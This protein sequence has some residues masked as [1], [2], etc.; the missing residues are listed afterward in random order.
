MNGTS[1]FRSLFSYKKVTIQQRAKKLEKTLD[2]YAK[3][4]K[5]SYKALNITPVQHKKSRVFLLF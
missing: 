3:N 1:A 2:S 4:K 5:I